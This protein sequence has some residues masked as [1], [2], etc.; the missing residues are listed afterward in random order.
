LDLTR[1]G[2]YHHHHQAEQEQEDADAVDPVHEPQTAVGIALTEQAA[3][4]EVMENA[5]QE[6]EQDG[7]FAFGPPS[8]G[9]RM[10]AEKGN[11][12]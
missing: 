12:R 9:L 11:R 6:H 8:Y 5:F 2:A 10:N 4:I 1:K 7:S 3:R